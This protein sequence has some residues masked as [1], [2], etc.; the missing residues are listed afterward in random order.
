MVTCEELVELYK[1]TSIK[2][3]KNII[4]ANIYDNLKN[5]AMKICH[6]YSDLLPISL[7]SEAFDDYL[8]ESKICLLNCIEK[9]NPELKNKFITFYFS[10]LKNDIK[11]QFKQQIKK[12]SN[13]IGYSSIFDCYSSDN[14]DNYEEHIDDNFLKK[15]FKKNIEELNYSKPIHKSIFL[16]YLGFSED[17]ESKNFSELGAKYKISRMGSKK[18]CN[19]Y[20]ELL[21][22]HLAN[23]GDIEKLKLFL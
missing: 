16:D 5:G 7:R 21:K 13:E 9:F 12:Y 20:M 18:I 8:S 22:K 4:Y 23:N 15:I 14:L 1:S 6:C 2:K 10:C 19:K 17:K 11:T 3:N